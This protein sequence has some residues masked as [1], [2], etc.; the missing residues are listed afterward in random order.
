MA[1]V[2]ITRL[3]IRDDAFL[4]EF[5]ADS[6]ASYAQA[7]AAAGNLGVDLLVE[8]A[9]TFWTRSTWTTGRPCAPS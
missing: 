2:S 8:V 4:E 1:Y 6:L 9:N 5:M 7:E 3:R